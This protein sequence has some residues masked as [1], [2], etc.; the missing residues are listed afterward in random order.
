MQGYI[1]LHRRFFTHWL[2]T[3]EREFSKREAFLDLLQ[4]AA[5]AH[6]KRLIK[7][8]V[9]ELRPGQL[10]GSERYL[11]GR[12]KWSTTRVRAFLTLLEA[13]KMVGIET[14]KRAGSVITL[15]NYGK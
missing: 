14:K 3:E 10:C 6:S 12:W 9:V 7:G 15:T 5:Y 2:W 4:L 11:A 8:D 1:I 13:D